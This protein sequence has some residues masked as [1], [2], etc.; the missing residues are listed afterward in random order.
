MDKKRVALTKQQF[1]SAVHTMEK[2]RWS[3]G[4]LEN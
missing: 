4:L 3:I 1:D 2:Q